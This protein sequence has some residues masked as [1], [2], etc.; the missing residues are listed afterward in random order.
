MEE[1]VELSLP[2]AG[3]GLFK[4]PQKVALCLRFRSLHSEGFPDVLKVRQRLQLGYPAVDHHREERE[5]EVGM[6]SQKPVRV[7]AKASE[8][9][10]FGRI[11]IATPCN[12]VDEVFCEYERYA[13]SID[14]KLLLSVVEKVAEV[15]V[16]QVSAL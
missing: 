13:L 9:P 16:E 10:E 2:R 5:N 8:V 15:D 6:R 3:G 4:L 14:P 1:P 7:T 12:D 11:R